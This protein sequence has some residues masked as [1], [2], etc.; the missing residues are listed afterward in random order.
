VE[1]VSSHAGATGAAVRD[2][3]AGGVRGL[4]VAGTGNGTVHR[5]LA[6]ALH[7]AQ[8]AGV[9]VLRSTR[10]RDGRVIGGDPSLAAADDLTPE[11]ARVELILQL[12]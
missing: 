11:K 5:S 6:A 7:E 4:V 2:L 8:A 12:L 9:R 10:C 3:V 1:I